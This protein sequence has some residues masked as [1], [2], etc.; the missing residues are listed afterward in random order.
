MPRDLETIVAKA[1]ARDPAERYATAGALAEDLRRF[2]EDRPIRARRV[3]VTEHLTRWARRNKGLAAALT[4]V[5]LL[6]VTFAVGSTI[7]AVWYQEAAA[8][9]GRLHQAARKQTED[10]RREDYVYRL[11]LADREIDASNLSAA[12]DLLGGCPEELRDSFEYRYVRRR[13]HLDLPRFSGVQADVVSLDYSPDGKWLF[14]AEGVMYNSK[15]TDHAAVVKRNA[16]TGEIVG[17]L[18]WPGA[19]ARSTSARTARGSR[20]ASGTTTSGPH[21]HL[22]GRGDPGRR[23]DIGGPLASSRPRP[24]V[25]ECRG[26]Q[27][28]Q[29]EDP[30]SATGPTTAP[31]AS[32]P[33]PRRSSHGRRATCSGRSPASARKRSVT[34]IVAFHPDGRTVALGSYE[35][36]ALYSLDNEEPADVIDTSQLGSLY[37]L[38]FSPDGSQL[39]SA[40]WGRTI[41]LWDT[42]TRKLLRRLNGH[43]GFIRDLVFSPDGR[44]LASASEDRSVRLWNVETGDLDAVFHGHASHAVSAA[45]HPGGLLLASGGIDDAIK[46]WDVRASRPII[47]WHFGWANGLAFDPSSD[48]G[49]LATQGHGEAFNGQVRL[50]NPT[51]GEPIDEPDPWDPASVTSLAEAVRARALEMPTASRTCGRG[52][53]EQGWRVFCLARPAA[54]DQGP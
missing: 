49:V 5:G 38:A 27:P 40:G 39:A 21:V 23:P 47:K 48:H 37:A 7:A 14:A 20:S 33:V 36:I 26:I 9:E 30:R 1:M 8:R 34:V 2:V 43:L 50:W 44:F 12:A 16:E 35:R 19:S 24:L 52:G 54:H 22:Q 45:W 4:T 10:L 51:T 42:K 18:P 31:F 3:S 15:S 17:K 13:A 41:H 28:G 11:A 32:S 29:L 6:L 46:L 53:L 25:G